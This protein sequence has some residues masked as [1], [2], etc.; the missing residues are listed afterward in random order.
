MAKWNTPDDKH[1]N[2]LETRYMYENRQKIYIANET[3]N[4]TWDETDVPDFITAWNNNWTMTEIAEYFGASTY[5]TQL[6]AGDLIQRGKISGNI[7]IFKPKSKGRSFLLKVYQVDNEDIRIVTE[8]GKKWVCMKDLWRFLQRP[9]HS[10]R[11][12]TEGW[13]PQERAKY[14]LETNSGRQNFIFISIH[15][16]DKLFAR[17][18]DSEKEKFE[19]IRRIING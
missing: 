16:M 1:V 18:K 14:K 5:E 12:T 13:K 6:L 4:M 17:L 3:E 7:H 11:K 8:K 19:K 15:G 10:Y 2:Y 9:E